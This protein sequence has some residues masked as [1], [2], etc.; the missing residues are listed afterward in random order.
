MKKKPEDRFSIGQILELINL[1]N[2][3]KNNNSLLFQSNFDSQIEVYESYFQE[4]SKSRENT[5][6]KTRRK[7]IKV[8]NQILNL[9]IIGEQ[10]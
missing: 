8:I 2:K 3:E 9:T 7:L 1:R 5:L 6:E 4:K 10:F